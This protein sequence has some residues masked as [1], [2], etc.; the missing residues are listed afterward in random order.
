MP[1]WTI[2]AEPVLGP[3]VDE[4]MREY[5]TEMGL[6]VLGRPGTEAELQAVLVEDPHHALSPPDGE[7]LVARGDGGEFLGCAGLRLLAGAPETAELKRM[8][9]RPAGRG[10]G[11]GRGLLLAVEQSARRLGATRIVCETNTQLTAARALYTRH[12]Y[13]ETGPYEGH[14]KADHWYAKALD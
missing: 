4:V 2:K 10:A 13:E 6:R 1:T 14:G 8:F 12:G 3:G 7:F 5:F 9:V 11:L